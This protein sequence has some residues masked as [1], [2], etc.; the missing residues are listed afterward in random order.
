MYLDF[1]KLEIS[2]VVEDV[3]LERQQCDN[4]PTGGDRPKKNNFDTVEEEIRP[5]QHPSV[6]F[7]NREFI[8]S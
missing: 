6:P 4:L 3:K 5:L 2:I 7:A 8:D 1:Y